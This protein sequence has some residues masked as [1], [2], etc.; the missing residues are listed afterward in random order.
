MSLQNLIQKRVMERLTFS[1]KKQPEE[2]PPLK[3]EEIAKSTV[4]SE[5]ND[6]LQVQ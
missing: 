6:S 5:N 3:N 1:E 4:G 2:D